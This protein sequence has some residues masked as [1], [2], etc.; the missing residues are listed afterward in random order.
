VC[1]GVAVWGFGEGFTWEVFF[2]DAEFVEFLEG[3][4]Y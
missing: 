2:V 1:E 4:D 3:F